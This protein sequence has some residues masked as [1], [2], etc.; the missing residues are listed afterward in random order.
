MGEV[1]VDQHT[2][3]IPAIWWVG[4]RT[5]VARG[6]R[7]GGQQIKRNLASKVLPWPGKDQ[8]KFSRKCGQRQK[9]QK[10]PGIL[11]CAQAGLHRCASIAYPHSDVPSASPHPRTCKMAQMVRR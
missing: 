7:R 9:S 1:S 4:G 8:D 3:R 5:A 2:E 10:P 6:A 11:A